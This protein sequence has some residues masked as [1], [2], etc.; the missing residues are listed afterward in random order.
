MRGD[1]QQKAISTTPQ[2]KLIHSA[3]IRTEDVRVHLERNIQ[4]GEEDK[5]NSHKKG[6]VKITPCE[7]Q[8]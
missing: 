8:K 3:L 5:R 4:Q 1:I 7:T 2:R 6:M